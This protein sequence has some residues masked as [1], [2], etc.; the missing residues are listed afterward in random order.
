[1]DFRKVVQETLE[2][3]RNREKGTVSFEDESKAEKLPVMGD[4]QLFGRVISNLIINGIQSVEEGVGPVVNVIL[5]EKNRKVVLEIKDNGKGIPDE[6]K[7]KI[8][9]PNFST[10]S[11]GSGLG[12]AIAKRGVETAGGNIWFETEIGKGSS[13]FLSFDLVK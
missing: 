11:E 12:L 13:F 3:F 2:L 1:M 4:D 9:L 10:K 5:K 7:D 8:F 6:L